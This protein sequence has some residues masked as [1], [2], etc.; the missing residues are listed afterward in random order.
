MPKRPLDTP[1]RENS[2]NLAGQLEEALNNI[3]LSAMTYDF[4][5][6]LLAFL[7]KYG[8][9]MEATTH[10]KG[11]NAGIMIAQ[12]KCNIKGG[13]IPTMEGLQAIQKYNNELN[14][15]TQDLECEWLWEIFLRYD[16]PTGN[17]KSKCPEE[18]K[19]K[20]GEPKKSSG[21][22]PI[23]KGGGLSQFIDSVNSAT[24][25]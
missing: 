20:Y 8:G 11:L 16:L 3:G 22:K 25:K 5:G 23:K 12:E 14:K 1:Y 15:E 24:G 6:K 4:A 7:L 10:H 21:S 2:T 13:C 19:A 9:G 17:L 18:L